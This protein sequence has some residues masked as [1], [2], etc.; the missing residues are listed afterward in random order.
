MRILH[1][2]VS[3]KG[4]DEK[5]RCMPGRDFLRHNWPA[6]TICVTATAIACA[7]LV[8]LR[9]MPPQRIIM[10]TGPEG[11]AYYEL[12]ERYR[13]ALARENVEVQLL[14]TAGSVEPGAAARSAFASKRCLDR[15]WH[16]R[17]WSFVRTRIAGDVVLRALVV[18]S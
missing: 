14:A 2:D 5:Y 3:G 1:F 13:A 17:R 12:G 8:M 15:G 7:A 9:S 16:P 6:I 18:V 4:C 10:T 11:D